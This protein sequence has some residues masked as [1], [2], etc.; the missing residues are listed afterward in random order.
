MDTPNIEL[1]QITFQRQCSVLNLAYEHAQIL[2]Y[3]PFLLQNLASLGRERSASH[4]NLQEDIANNVEKCL[5]AALKTVEMFQK[6]CQTRRMYNSFWV[7]FFRTEYLD[8]GLTHHGLQFTHY[9]VFCAIVVLYVYI[10][11]NWSDPDREYS[12]YLQVGEGAQLELAKCG[13]QSSF[14][15]RYVVVLE[16]LRKEAHKITNQ[17]A[18]DGDFLGIASP[19]AGVTETVIQQDQERGT[20]ENLQGQGHQDLNGWLS[21]LAQDTSP[22]SCLA[23]MTG[24]GDF[25][26]FVLT[27]LGDLNYLLPGGYS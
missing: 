13:N 11:Q 27:G 15:Q 25:D 23:D 16:E 19:S 6:L 4:S 14:A 18:G 20:L 26:S 22:P 5:Q 21:E 3:R 17:Y 2:L 12:R 8:I 1:L 7:G 10:V 9:N 24:W